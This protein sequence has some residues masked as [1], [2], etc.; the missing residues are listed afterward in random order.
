[1]TSHTVCG[2]TRYTI[3]IDIWPTQEEMAALQAEGHGLAVAEQQVQG[4]A[5]ETPPPGPT[6]L[7]APAA[8]L[9]LPGVPAQAVPLAGV[10]IPAVLPSGVAPAPA[11]SVLGG[12]GGLAALA[13]AIG[14]GS[15]VPPGAPA[16]PAPAPAA[17]PVPAPGWP[18]AA[19]VPD[20]IELRVLPIQHDI[21]RQSFRSFDDSVLI[22]EEVIQ[23]D[24][25]VK[26]PS[27]VLWCW[28]FIREHAGTPNQ[29]HIRWMG[30][31]KL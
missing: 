13:A 15:A 11:A 31:C 27:T 17:L 18:G 20:A 8:A 24:S 3:S 7:P 12:G 14:G 4:W 26:G 16:M 28:C 29:W 5:L 19:G 21:A 30:I 9:P 22:L 2:G 25:P 1:M 10:A 6:L 23:L